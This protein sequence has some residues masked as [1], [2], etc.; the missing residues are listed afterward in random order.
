MSII[1]RWTWMDGPGVHNFNLICSFLYIYPWNLTQGH[2]LSNWHVYMQVYR[3]EIQHLI[4]TFA[5]PL[6]SRHPPATKSNGDGYYLNFVTQQ[7][8]SM[9]AL[10][11]ICPSW[12]LLCVWW[13]RSQNGSYQKVEEICSCIW[14]CSDVLSLCLLWRSHCGIKV[15]EINFFTTEHLCDGIM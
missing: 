14:V 12:P 3:L 10:S 8:Q 6:M 5:C 11:Q 9:C 1:V 13:S 4:A 2:G 7:H 15:V